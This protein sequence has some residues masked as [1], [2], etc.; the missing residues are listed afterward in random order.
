MLRPRLNRGDVERSF[1]SAPCLRAASEASL[2]A[3]ATARRQ[4]HD[5]TWSAISEKC[6]FRLSASDGSERRR[7]MHVRRRRLASLERHRVLL[8]E[9]MDALDEQQRLVQRFHLHRAD[10]VELGTCGHYFTRS[11]RG[12][13]RSRRPTFACGLPFT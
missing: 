1:G 11:R 3:R 7:F 6:A 2:L 13:A 12:L 10:R 4:V 8:D 5:K 9:T